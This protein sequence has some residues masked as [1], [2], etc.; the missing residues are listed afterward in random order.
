MKLQIK[1]RAMPTAKSVGL[2]AVGF[3]GSNAATKLAPVK[4][5]K[6]APIGTLVVGLGCLLT[7]SEELQDLGKGIATSS[8]MNGISIL[9]A[10]KEGEV[11]NKM[12]DMIKPLAGL[13]SELEE[14]PELMLID[15][16]EDEYNEYDEEIDASDLQNI[17]ASDD[18][19]MK[20]L[21][22]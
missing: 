20:K 12:I 13:D 21:V 3:L 17:D 9:T 2:A 8:A 5:R 16:V 10:P 18:T 15:G 11:P 19:L 7:D 1:E 22:G 6:F 14:Y 4:F